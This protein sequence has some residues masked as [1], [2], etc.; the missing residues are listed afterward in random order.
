VAV[1]KKKSQPA[2]RFNALGNFSAVVFFNGC[3]LD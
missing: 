1:L 3:L 2:I